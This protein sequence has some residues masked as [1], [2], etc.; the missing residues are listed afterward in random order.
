MFVACTLLIT[1]TLGGV[2]LTFLYARQ[3]RF[4]ARLCM[5]AC[6][7]LA[8]LATIGF[9]L[10]SSWGLTATTIAISCGCMLLPFLLL[11]N[12]S[13]RECAIRETQSA[14]RSLSKAVA[15]PDHASVGYFFFYLCTA[16]LL[17]L[18]FG[19]ALFQRSDGIY[20]GLAN[21]LGDL[22]MH[23]QV[24]FSFTNG[25]NFPTED[26]T[27]AGVRFTYSLLSD[28]LTAMLV[29]AGATVAQ[30]MWMQSMVLGLA[31]VGL[32]HSWTIAMT[33]SRLAGMIA[34]L[35]VVFSGGLGWCFIF[36]D[37]HSSET[38]LLPLLANLPRDYTLMSP[39]ILRWGNSLTTLFVPQRSFLL[40]MPLALCIFT[41]WWQ[42]LNSPHPDPQPGSRPETSS[43]RSENTPH[44]GWL[45]AAAGFCAG[46]LPLTHAYTFMVVLGIGACLAVIFSSLWRSWLVFFGI[47]LLV[48]LPEILWL[49]H[50]TGVNAQ[51][52]LGWQIGWDRGND[53]ALWFWFVNTGFFIPL[54]I[55]AIF[56]RKPG[57]TM[58]KR[59]IRFYLP[60]SLCFIVPNVMKLAP[61]IWDNIKVLFYWY[62]ASVPLVAFLLAYWLKQKSRL[63]WMAAS[64]LAALLLAGGLDLWRVITNTTE[65]REFD[66]NGI[67][68][69]N[70]IMQLSA[71]RAVILHA[72]TFNSP[73][74]LTG[75]RSLLG[76]T[77]WL[78]SHG[79][80]SSE[81]ERDIQK[82]YGG[83]PDAVPL[84]DR[85][86][87][88]YVLVGPQER[89]SFPVD[90]KF[91]SHYPKM[92]QI[93]DYQ[94][95]KV[96]HGK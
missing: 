79:L 96:D 28:F 34:P 13:Y 6:T 64:L 60:F 69:A 17:G 52:Y 70:L 31:M 94:L 83:S 74:F 65:Y 61:W 59:L 24:I 77:G 76:F 80:D 8:L 19:R 72:P 32:I 18:V 35:L 63:R 81:R 54:L 46:L 56:W 90:E 37:L 42:S 89:Q 3:A 11:L 75:R 78:W 93:G 16:I 4:A 71:P 33:R 82:M 2:M 67:A 21:N 10:A 9:V 73:V 22:P 23:L 1:A 43:H 5:G 62:I 40:G 49:S 26:P 14:A 84:L 86:K 87:V 12:R 51:K 41:W 50:S 30:A 91:W 44:P 92:S 55:A 85:Y 45:M 39:G 38:G 27:Y 57:Y 48:A 53:N 20:T 15:H 66:N 58:P 88:D 68:T 36:Q 47:A 29:R 95:Y 25:H 7:G